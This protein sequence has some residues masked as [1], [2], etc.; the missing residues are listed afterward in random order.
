MYSEDETFFKIG[1]TTSTKERFRKFKNYSVEL[2][3]CL[4]LN[5][6]DAIL[7]ESDL[8]LKH[9]EYKYSPIKPFKGHSE[10]FSTFLKKELSI[11]VS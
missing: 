9:K 6:Y 11:A 1:I 7:L 2:I 3:E 10:C 8:H 5:R 4:S